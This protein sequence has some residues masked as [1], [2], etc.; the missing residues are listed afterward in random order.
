MSMRWRGVRVALLLLMLTAV[1]VPSVVKAADP[2]ESASEAASRLIRQKQ[3]A[4]NQGNRAA[5]LSVLNPANHTYVEEQ[6][7]WFDDAIRW[8][9]PGTYRL[10]LISLIPEREHQLRAWVEQGYR[11]N[12]T[13]HRVRFPLSLQE[14]ATGWKDSDHP[15]HHLTQGNVLVRYSDPA[16]QEQ[17]LIVQEAASKALVEF[18]R[19]LGWSPQGQVEIKIYR[20]PEVF[21]Q[22]VKPSLPRWAGGWHE[23]GQAIKLV[24]A[25]S[26]TD[27]RL[28]SSTVV[29]E[30]THRMVSEQSGDNAAYWLQEGAAEYYQS[31]LLPGLIQEDETDR[32]LPRWS[33]Q[34]LEQ[35][36]LESLPPDKAADYYTQCDQLFR[37]IVHRFG[38]T[39]VKRIWS[40]LE[41]HPTI[42]RD[43]ADK[44]ETSN[45]RTRDAL[46]KVT[47]M[48]L[49]EL[50]REWLNWMKIEKKDP[51]RNESGLNG[52]NYAP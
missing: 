26:Y 30:L 16:Q 33:L 20:D 23:A 38:Q 46:K 31:H 11:K 22:S 6:S 25:D 50:E 24:G 40:T 29:H 36:R 27:R 49:S 18:Q 42:D 44:M 28:L 15:F 12:G 7:R 43:G 39:S 21:R 45:Q 3:D 4:V 41:L 14:T 32:P 37:F 9:D 10:R 17:A 2:V 52:M 34:E 1:M 13:W 51:F 8:M 19:Q 5:Y 48:T 35:V 47:G